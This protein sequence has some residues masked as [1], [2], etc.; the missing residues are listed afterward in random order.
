MTYHGKDLQELY[1][2]QADP[3]EHHDLARDEAAA[4][5]V[6]MLTRRSFDATVFAHP[7]MPPRDHP[8]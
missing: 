7:P 3:W 6:T 5:L 2:L 1:D 4:S 8:F